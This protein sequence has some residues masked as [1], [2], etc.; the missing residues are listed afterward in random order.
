MEFS[1][2]E[3]WSGS[4]FPATPPLSPSPSALIASHTEQGQDDGSESYPAIQPTAPEGRKQA[5]LKT[6]PGAQIRTVAALMWVQAQGAEEAED[7]PVGPRL[8]ALQRRG[9]RSICG[10]SVS[11]QPQPVVSA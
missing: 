11:L 2:E 6:V 3:Y 8:P 1:R 4:L 9:L 10:P 5:Q 7:Q